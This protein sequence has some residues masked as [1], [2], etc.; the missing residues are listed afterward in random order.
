[1]DATCVRLFLSH[2][3]KR[4]TPSSQAVQQTGPQWLWP[5]CRKRCNGRHGRLG[6]GHH[7][8]F[9]Q[10]HHPQATHVGRAVWSATLPA[11]QEDFEYYLTA[12]GNLVWPATAPGLNQTVVVFPQTPKG[13]EE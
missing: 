8:L 6:P 5:G 3:A 4:I 11:A 2:L 13:V 1:M 7:K 9:I 10:S 12:G